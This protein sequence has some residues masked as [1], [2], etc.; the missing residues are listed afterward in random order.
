[1]SANAIDLRPILGV[2]PMTSTLDPDISK[3]LD[4]K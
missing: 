4:E 2:V 1:M 3:Q